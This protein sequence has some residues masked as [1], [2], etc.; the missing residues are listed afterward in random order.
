MTAGGLLPPLVQTTSTLLPTTSTRSSL[1]SITTVAGG[2]A[3]RGD[4]CELETLNNNNNHVELEIEPL[5]WE[6]LLT[7]INY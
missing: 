2:T 7:I 5:L 6:Q 4:D 3:M 1:F